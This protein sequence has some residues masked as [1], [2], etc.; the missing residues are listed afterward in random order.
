MEKKIKVCFLYES[1]FTLGGIQACI[2]SIANYLAEKQKYDITI[3]CTN[4]KVL[5][6]REIYGLKDNIKVKFIS[7]RSLIKKVIYKV[8]K[9][10]LDFNR[11]TGFFKN[12]LK[13]LTKLYYLGYGKDLEKIINNEQFDFVISCGT[14][15]NVVLS[16]LKCE[17]KVKKI[18]WQHSSNE[19]YFNTEGRNY[20]NQEIIVKEMFRKLDKYIVLTKYDR[21]ELL[22]KGYEATTIYNPLR[23]EQKEKSLLN[24][25]KFIAVGRLNKIKGFDRLIRNF[26]QFTKLNK[27][28]KLEIF[29]EGEERNNLIELINELKLDKYVS[30]RHKTNR[31]NEEYINASIYCMTSQGEGFPMVILEA[32]ES[33]LPI[34]AYKLPCLEEI[35]NN[36]EG[37]LV[38]QD[39]DEGFIRAMLKLTDKEENRKYFSQNAIK[40]AKEFSIDIIGKQWEELLN[41]V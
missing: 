27:D 13:V 41:K 23:F 10:I 32:M 36:D 17:K 11:N 8:S 15:F 33:G 16:L 9:K 1:V 3:L 21:N 38:N 35:M 20:W 7:K 34:I 19:L 37:I 5:E 4:T 12:N 24:N 39:D 18:G 25:K 22:A 31:I 2:T 26:K 6:K 40:R 29:G 28:W 14:Y 30:I